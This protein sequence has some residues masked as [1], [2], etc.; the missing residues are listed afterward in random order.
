VAARAVPVALDR[1]GRKGARDAEILAEAVQQV[2]RQHGLVA[3][4]ERADRADLEL[5]LAGHDLG[6]DAADG[7]AGLEAGL[8]VGLCEKS[9]WRVGQDWI[10]HPLGA[11]DRKSRVQG[12]LRS[13]LKGGRSAPRPMALGGWWG[14]TDGS[15]RAPSSLFLFQIDAPRRTLIDLLVGS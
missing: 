1:F 13:H 15:H 8:H 7:E 2:A 10:K 6:V 12:L 11:I 5:P 9:G 14:A 3:E 4:L